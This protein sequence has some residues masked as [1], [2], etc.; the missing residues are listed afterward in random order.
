MFVGMRLP[1]GSRIFLVACCAQVAIVSAGPPTVG[2]QQ[3][4][5]IAGQTAASNETSAAARGGDPSEIVGTWNDWRDSGKGEVIRLG[6]ALSTNGGLAWSDFLVRPPAIFQSTVEG[7][8]MATV[9]PRTGSLWVGAISFAANGGL[10]VARKEPG[11]DFFQ[12]SVMADTGSGID[13]GWMAAGRNEITP[14]STAVYIAYNLGV[15]RS[16]DLGD[17]WGSTV[18]LGGGLGF[19]PRVGPSGEVYVSS[20]ANGDVF[21]L[22]RSLDGGQTFVSRTIALRMDS[23]GVGENN[24]RFPGTFRVPQLPTLAVDPSSGT[25]YAAWPDTTDQAAGQANVDVYFSRSTDQGDSWTTPVIVNGEGPNVGDQ[26]FPWIEVDSQGRVH[27]VYLDSRHTV[28]NDNDVNGFFDAYYAYSEDFGESWTEFRLTPVSW[29]S[30]DDGLDREFQFIG[31]YL[32]MAVAGDTVWPVYPDTTH[33]DTDIY[34]NEISFDSCLAPDEVGGL[35]VDRSAEN[36]TLTLNWT[37]L[38]NTADYI[39]FQNFAP[40]GAFGFA[41][42]APSGVPGLTLAE[43]AGTRYYLVAARNACGIG[44]K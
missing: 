44:P 9:D 19:L 34:T 3:R 22:Q 41:G 14:D 40:V 37:D 39:V 2:P 15:V 16:D 28:Q 29:N 1:V 8:P 35:R 7:D 11:D 25:L 36:G 26:F 17:S 10:Y 24:S 13:K 4:I 43:P 5:D 12:P 31:D 27:L 30:D 23:W 18:S 20:W 32:G 42:T 21:R 6:V 33:G 38:P